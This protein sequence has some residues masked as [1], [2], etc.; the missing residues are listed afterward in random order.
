MDATSSAY[1]VS[2][3]VGILEHPSAN[4]ATPPG[5]PALGL[6]RLPVKTARIECDGDYVGVW[7]DMILNPPWSKYAHLGPGNH[8]SQSLPHLIAHWNIAD[9][10]TGQVLP[11]TEASMAYLPPELMM[12]LVDKWAAARDFRPATSDSSATPT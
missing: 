11:V 2:G 9:P 8:V 12:Q 10:E 1:P 3:Q 7:A 5:P 6:V 4:G